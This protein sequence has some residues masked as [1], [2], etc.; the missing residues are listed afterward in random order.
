[1]AASWVWSIGGGILGLIV[2]SFLATITVRW[3]QGRSV[4]AGRS[5]C[6]SCGTTIASRDLVPVVSHILL[7]GRCR[8]CD[9]AIGSDHLRIE[10]ASGAI[11]ALSLAILPGAAGVALALMGWLLLASGWID[12]RHLMLPDSLT[13]ALAILGLGVGGLV[14]GASL[15]ARMI[16]GVAAFG[17]LEAIR[18]LYLRLRGHDGMGG[19][20]PKLLGAIGLWT[21]WTMLPFVLLA[22]SLALLAIA[23]AT[24]R[25]SERAHEYPLG[26]ALAAA[27]YG[28]AAA[29][30]AHLV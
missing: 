23:L 28:V 2:G 11:G 27:G 26:T 9:A 17:T 18:L 13:L 30:A 3:P 5:R 24:G 15:E 10:L 16:G 6:D 14:T 8:S 22:A 21:G 19:G 20:D 25:A 29:M 1:M 7:R 4:V 12:A